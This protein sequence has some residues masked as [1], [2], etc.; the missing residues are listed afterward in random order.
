MESS[1]IALN[2]QIGNHLNMDIIN[3]SN[4]LSSFSFH[5]CFQPGKAKGGSITVP[6]TSC[7]TGLES[8]VWQLTIFVLFA[9]Q[10][11]PNQSNRRSTVLSPLVFPAP[12]LNVEMMRQ[13]F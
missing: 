3:A 8:A 10:T 4:S 5:G 13:V 7:L 9:K 1:P 6:L 11:N 2:K 12:T